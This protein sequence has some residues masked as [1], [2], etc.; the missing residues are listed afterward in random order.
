M[1][2]TRG[3]WSLDPRPFP[4]D[5]RSTTAFCVTR[6]GRA[7]HKNRRAKVISCTYSK[8]TLLNVQWELPGKSPT[9]QEIDEFY[10][11]QQGSPIWLANRNRFL[12]STVMLVIICVSSFNGPVSYWKWL[13]REY[14]NIKSEPESLKVMGHGTFH[15]DPVRKVFNVSAKTTFYEV[16]TIIYD[17]MPGLACNVDGVMFVNGKLVRLC[18]IKCPVFQ[19]YKDITKFG[20]PPI[21]HF[22][23]CQINMNIT[24]CEEIYYIMCHIPNDL[25]E[26]RPLEF[27]KR[28]Y[29]HRYLCQKKRVDPDKPSDEHVAIGKTVNTTPLEEIPKIGILHCI[30]VKRSRKIWKYVTDHLMRFW[31]ENVLGFQ[32]PT[33]DAST[34]KRDYIWFIEQGII[35]KA[36][37][38]ALFTPVYV[39]LAVHIE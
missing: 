32:P 14:S 7:R 3:I 6:K 25:M 29:Y 26:K 15:E 19:P 16:G 33:E 23:Q 34:G 21:S 9:Q 39:E 28:S 10:N 30:A 38:E 1:T 35:G 31:N 5:V 17:L 22:F 2:E 4:L 36:E 37:L 24:D 20:R 13:M 18:E 12:T 11:M 27:C 8:V